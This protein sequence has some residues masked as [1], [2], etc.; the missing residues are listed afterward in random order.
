MPE[1]WKESV[2]IP[3]CKKGEKTDCSDYRGISL[4]STL[5]IILLSVLAP[6]AKEILVDR[7]CG[8]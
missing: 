5:S 8:F 4:L 1:Q 2:N 3:F 6:Y 7:Q